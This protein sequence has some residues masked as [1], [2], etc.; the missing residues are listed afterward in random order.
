[1]RVPEEPVCIDLFR[2]NPVFTSL[3]LNSPVHVRR[4]WENQQQIPA[5]GGPSGTA[6]QGLVRRQSL[7]CQIYMHY[8]TYKNHYQVYTERMNASIG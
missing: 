8:I 3:H 7:A 4:L 1:M 5:K 6:C 2:Q